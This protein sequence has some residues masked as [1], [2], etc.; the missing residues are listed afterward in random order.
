MFSQYYCA[1]GVSIYDFK[2][3]DI[4]QG[5][6]QI[7]FNEKR[8][9]IVISSTRNRNFWFLVLKHDKKYTY[10]N[11]PRFTPEESIAIMEK[12][13]DLCVTQQTSMKDL[14][15]KRTKFALASLEEVVFKQWH[16]GRIV[17]VGDSAH[18]V[19]LRKPCKI[20]K[21]HIS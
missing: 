10:P 6:S 2:D 5:A 18:K 11:I 13:T 20:E 4:V 15:D 12:N 21:C 19:T 8:S 14:W 3:P 7:L 17:L 9:N 16:E 1:F